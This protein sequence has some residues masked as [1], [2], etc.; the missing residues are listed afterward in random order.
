MPRDGGGGFVQVCIGADDGGALAAQLQCH[1]LDCAG[2]RRSD[3][4]AS[5][6]AAGKGNLAGEG[7][8]DHRHANPAATPRDHVETA[9]RI[10]RLMEQFCQKQGGKRGIL[11]GFGHHGAARDQRG[12]QFEAQ[13]C[14]RIVEGSDRHHY[15][16]RFASYNDLFARL[17]DDHRVMQAQPFLGVNVQKIGGAL[18][19]RDRRRDGAA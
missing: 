13:E 11:G 6:C 9:R 1:P 16:Y 7:V 19:F 14:N 4:L 3:C 12:A 8:V 10:T 2:R 5:R 17:A 15:A 18:E